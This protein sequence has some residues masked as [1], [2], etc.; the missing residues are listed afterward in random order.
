MRIS[1]TPMRRADRLV[2]SKAGDVLTINGTEIDF[3]AIP[4]GGLCPRAAVP[5]DWLASDVERKGGVIHL[6]LILPHGPTAPDD[7][8]F[9]VPIMAADGPVPVPPY[10]REDTA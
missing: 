2:L 8:L 6:T 7:T 3:S 9:P 5:C 10:A 4:E 1:F